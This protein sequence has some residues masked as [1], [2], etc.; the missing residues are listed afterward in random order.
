[1][2]RTGSLT[3]RS[4][5]TTRLAPA[6]RQRRTSSATTVGS[7]LAACSGSRS[8]PALGLIRTL[9]PFF[10]NAAIPPS[11]ETARL[12]FDAGSAPRAWAPL[13]ADSGLAT[14]Q[15]GMPGA[16]ASTRRRSWKKTAPPV[17]AAAATPAE[18]R[19]AAI[20]RRVGFS[21]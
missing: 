3:E 12:T 5:T 4:A 14:R 18:T 16:A 1:M 2:E 10:T 6:A 9:S 21:S 15:S 11:A 17:T 19:R 20:S 7:V 8:Q 13:G